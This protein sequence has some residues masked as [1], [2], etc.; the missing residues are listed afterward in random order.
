MKP[1]FCFF[2]IWLPSFILAQDVN[3]RKHDSVLMFKQMESF[4]ERFGFGK[5]VPD[6]YEVAFLQLYPF[7][8]S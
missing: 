4:K 5:D 8:L 1:L 2:L 7:I 3:I 6:E